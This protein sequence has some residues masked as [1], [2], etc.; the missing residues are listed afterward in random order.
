[1]ATIRYVTRHFSRKTTN[2]IERGIINNSPRD[3]TLAHSY[4]NKMIVREP[5][6]KSKNM[7]PQL[8]KRMNVMTQAPTALNFKLHSM[9]ALR[10]EQQA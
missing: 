6:D 5:V 3:A 1:M 7:H 9:E 4:I 10:A 2:F 8:K